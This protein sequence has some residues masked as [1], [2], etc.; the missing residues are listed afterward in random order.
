MNEGVQQ[1]IK[2]SSPARRCPY[3]HD[4]VGHSETKCVCNSCLAVSHE[5]CWDEARCCP[6]C[7]GTDRLVQEKGAEKSSALPL[8]RRR[9]GSIKDE[10]YELAPQVKA[11]AKDADLSSCLQQVRDSARYQEVLTIEGQNALRD[12]AYEQISGMSDP[13][14]FFSGDRLMTFA[15]AVL[16]ALF[17]ILAL[18]GLSTIVV[19]PALFGF[20]YY[21]ANMDNKLIGPAKRCR[22]GGV[23]SYS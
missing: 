11:I 15:M 3:C 6:S 7:S 13:S 12:K 17:L 16:F 8:E 4:S 14:T 18:G 21:L 2:F 1:G 9:R 10:E 19:G 5:G 20:I 23:P 22:I